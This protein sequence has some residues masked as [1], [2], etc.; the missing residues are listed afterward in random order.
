M[1][2]VKKVNKLMQIILDANNLYGWTI[3]QYLPYSEFKW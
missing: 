3:I 1:I 2:V